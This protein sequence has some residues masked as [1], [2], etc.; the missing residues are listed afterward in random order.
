MSDFEQ[1]R[2][3]NYNSYL[4]GGRRPKIVI[5]AGGKKYFLFPRNELRPEWAD[6]VFDVLPI[7]DS[8]T[9][10]TLWVEEHLVMGLEV[11]GRLIISPAQGIEYCERNRRA[12]PWVAVGFFVAAVYMYCLGRREGL[13][14][15]LSRKDQRKYSS[16]SKRR[17]RRGRA[18]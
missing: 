10:A 1:V 4:L 8:S 15:K 12:A 13:D 14:W 3:S 17:G 2:I 5:E 11:G 18:A 7:L 16:P 9:E 6:T